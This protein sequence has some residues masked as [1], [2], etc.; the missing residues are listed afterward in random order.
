MV[1]EQGGV[2]AASVE[3]TGKSVKKTVLQEQAK[4]LYQLQPLARSWEVMWVELWEEFRE[5]LW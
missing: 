1:V 5:A 2:V 4:S 3:D